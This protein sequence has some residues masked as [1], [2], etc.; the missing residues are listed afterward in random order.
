M[1][2]GLSDQNA[3]VYLGIGIGKA[4]E[5]LEVAISRG[6]HNENFGGQIPLF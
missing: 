3:R 1:A 4:V 6:Q 5:R 2:N